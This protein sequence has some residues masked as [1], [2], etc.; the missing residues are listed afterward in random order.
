VQTNPDDSLIGAIRLGNEAV[1]E[2]IFRQH[3]APLCRYAQSILHDADEAEEM[4]QTVF[5]TIWERR[6]TLLIT[7]SL[8]AYLYRA[9]HNRCLN[10]LEQQQTQANH[11][12]RAATELYADVPSPN[13]AVLA[14]ELSQH[15]QRAIET[16]PDQCRRA[17]ELSRFEELSY[18]EIAERLG[19]AIKTVE[20]QIGKA[21]RILRTELSDYLPLL[22][23]LAGEPFR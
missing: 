3:Y 12:L 15:L 23:L 4:V 14:D 1:F 5:L 7:T 16:L 11:R 21:L 6:E 13:Q 20:N 2:E 18:K 9:V 10:R 17:F 8:K 19:I 22:L